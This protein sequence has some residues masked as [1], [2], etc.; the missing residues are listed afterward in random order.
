[1]AGYASRIQAFNSIA[2]DLWAKA[3]VIED[4]TGKRLAIITTDVIGF[5]A[6]I[7]APIFKGITARTGIQRADI[8]LTW[9]HTHSGPRLTLNEGTSPDSSERDT[10]NSVAYTLG[11][12]RHA[13]PAAGDSRLGH[14]FRCLRDEPSSA[15]GRRDTP[16]SKSERSRRP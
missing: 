3:L 4:E 5:K 15:H 14:G 9:S 2:G 7:A 1:M 11:G 13:K 10:R 6:E 8:L 16:Q 12:S